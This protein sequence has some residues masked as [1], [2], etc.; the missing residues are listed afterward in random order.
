MVYAGAG[1]GK[2]RVI[3]HRIAHLLEATDVRPYEIMAVTFTNKA[4]REMQERLRH[5]LASSRY[6]RDAADALWVGTFHAICA[7]LIRAHAPHVGVQTNFTIYDDADQRSM[8]TRV[9]RS[10][11]LDERSADP[12]TVA[13][14]I[15]RAKQEGLAP[16]ELSSATPWDARF[17]QVYL[18][19]E[20]AMQAA[21]ALD[22]DDLIARLV[23]ALE[24]EPGFR[25]ALGR[26]FRYIL[27]DEFQDTNRI[28]FRLVQALAEAHDNLCVVGDDDQSIYKWRGADRRNILDFSRTYPGATT[29]KLEQN[30][31][32]TKRIL[33]AAHAIICK[34]ADREPKTLWTE[35]R[36]GEPIRVICCA[37]ERN[38]AETVVKHVQELRAQGYALPKMAVFYRTHAQSRVLEETLRG[39]GIPYR[40]FGGLRFYDRAEVKDVLAYLRVLHNPSDEVSLL[41]IVNTPARGIGKT[42]LERALHHADAHSQTLWTTF[43]NIDQCP[44]VQSAA[45]KRI[46]EFMTWLAPLQAKAQLP[47]VSVVQLAE[48]ILDRSGYVTRLQDEDNA[49]SDTRIQNVREL[50]GSMRDFDFAWL[51][52]PAEGRTPLSY[53]LERVSLE[54]DQD[55]GSADNE[56]LSLMTVHAAKGLEF[57]VVFVV[58]VEEDIFPYKRMQ[59]VQDRRET[60]ESLGEERRLAYVALTR[61][62]ER[63]FLTH[64]SCRRLFG[65]LKVNMPSRFLDELP[66]ADVQREATGAS[67]TWSQW[68]SPRGSGSFAGADEDTGAGHGAWPGARVQTGGGMHVYGAAATRTAR[69]SRSESYVDRS[70]SQDHEHDSG[71][72]AVRPGMKVRH[73]KFGVGRVQAVSPSVPPKVTVRFADWGLKQVVASYLEPA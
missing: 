55:R 30:Y 65:Q 9:I 26:R 47:D 45:R 68:S 4:A 19:Y 16:Q 1:S 51:A 40:I 71:L 15:S 3:V 64:A 58:G 35:N 43:C 41:R 29:I 56:W 17:Q 42:T 25:S 48:E 59:E 20:R 23:R 44:T 8:V 69:A 18:E 57:P 36:S 11:G 38:E 10:L 53:F 31:R 49:E 34:D 70:D 39:H 2:T 32:S 50:V 46:A 7:R 61:A 66:A 13:H 37:D 12:K 24:Q 6:G 54:T 62:Q 28:Q 73:T 27:V 60:W 33:R 72:D 21:N 52:H 5:L 22:F 63:L 14:R 67:N